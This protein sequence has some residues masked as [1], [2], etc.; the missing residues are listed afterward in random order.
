MSTVTKGFSKTLELSDFQYSSIIDCKTKLLDI[1][2]KTMPQGKIGIFG[3]YQV[4]VFYKRNS[5]RRDDNYSI[6]TIKK[7]FCDVINCEEVKE[8]DITVEKI[9][10]EPACK[11]ILDRRNHISKIQIEAPIE[12]SYLVGEN[13]EKTEE[14]DNESTE[15]SEEEHTSSENEEKDEE[16][17][18]LQFNDEKY[19]IEE[20]MNMDLDTLKEI[21]KKD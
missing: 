8:E 1:F 20:M 4:Y 21:A 7:S 3:E 13:N 17:D 19:S 11:F 6:R 15:V 10:F 12:V 2:V 5:N 16:I 14:N 9:N 18:V